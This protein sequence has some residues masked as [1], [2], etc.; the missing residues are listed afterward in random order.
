MAVN[1][2]RLVYFDSFMDPIANAIIGRRDDIDLV[3][4]EYATPEPDN[5]TEITQA[6]GYQIQPRGELREPWFGDAALLARCPNMLAISST[7]AG[8]DMIDVDACTAA[9]V[10]VV[11]QSGTNWEPVAEHALGMMLSLTK[12]IALSERAM[13]RT[14]NLDRRPYAGNNLRNK[15]VGIIGI[16]HI[17][18]RVAELCGVLFDNTVLAY[19][20]YLTTEQV[21]ARG[22]TKVELDELL[23]RS[24]YVTV[25]C[26]RSSET[27]GMFGAAQFAAMKPSAYFINTARGGIHDEPALEAALRDGRIA[28]A[29]LDVFLKEPPD[30]AP[31]AAEHGQRH[32]QPAHRRHDRR[33]DDRDVRGDRPAM[34]HHLRWRRAAAPGQPRGLAALRRPFLRVARLPSGRSAGCTD[35]RGLLLAMM[36]PPPA[37]EEEFQDWYDT[38][39]F[40]ERA[41]CEGFLTAGRFVCIDGWPRYLA[42]YDLADTDVLRGPAYARIAGERY[43]P[44]THRIVSRVWGQYRADAAQ[45]HPGTALFGDAGAASRIA[46]WRFRNAPGTAEAPILDGLRTLYAERPETAQARLFRANQPDGT[47]YI[48]I[49]ELRAP[50]APAGQVAAFGDAARYVDL[51]NVYV[52]YARRLAGAFPRGT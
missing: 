3:R 11:N 39:H 50:I 12:K 24:D 33:D 13:K 44:W 47:D 18:R 36:E 27:F 10:I 26:P 29:G 40:P 16:G 42:L 46:L 15:T 31:S 32:R 5:W 20:P 2:K 48:A 38:E 51:I 43:S 45:V 52:P 23:R 49:V 28:G 9:G 25:H 6:H 30:P 7:G 14:A 21:A 4:L 22:A 37:M 17:G 41:N 34:A 19:D 8:Y 35:M 1:L